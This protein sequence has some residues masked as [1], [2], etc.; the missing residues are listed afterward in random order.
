MVCD[1]AV[2]KLNLPTQSEIETRIRN[3]HFS[4]LSSRY[5]AQL[6]RKAIIEYKDG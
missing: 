2:P 4:V 5:L 3:R 1:K 6:R